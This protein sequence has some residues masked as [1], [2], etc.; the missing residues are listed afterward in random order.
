MRLAWVL[1]A[2]LSI[3]A[4]AAHGQDVAGDPDAEARVLFEAGVYAFNGDRYA[5]ALE[6]FER[7]YALS[8]RPKLLYNI[9]LAADRL[10]EEERALES[11][12]AYLHEL[13]DAE[14]RV[15][16]EARIAVLRRAL[17]PPEDETRAAEPAGRVWTWV[18]G[19]AAVLFGATAGVLWWRARAIYDDLE[20][21]CRPN[22]CTQERID[23]SG[24]RTWQALGNVSI[25]VAAAAAV[26]AVVLFFVEGGG[27]EG[28]ADVRVGIGPG[29]AY[30]EGRF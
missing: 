23:D 19:G 24:G 29:G 7:S 11:F 1:G 14:N 18:T 8:R 3:S 20:A 21:E 13:P 27:A 26:G 16:V 15:D 30:A 4:G 6:H 12:E 5:E 22:R 10:Q 2:A 17:Q 28:E 9:G 25:A